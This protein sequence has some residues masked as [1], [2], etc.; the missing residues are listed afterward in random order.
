M[1]HAMRAVEEPAG[2]SIQRLM[3]KAR[4]RLSGALD[5]E[6]HADEML[7]QNK[8]LREMH[9]NDEDAVR[10]DALD[11]LSFITRCVLDDIRTGLLAHMDGSCREVFRLGELLDM[12]VRPPDIHQ[13]VYQR[14]PPS[15]PDVRAES[16]MPLWGDFHQPDHAGG[17]L[18]NQSCAPG[19]FGP[20]HGWEE[21]ISAIWSN[22]LGQELSAPWAGN[23]VGRRDGGP[24]REVLIRELQESAIALLAGSSTAGHA[25]D[26]AMSEVNDGDRLRHKPTARSKRNKFVIN[27]YVK[28]R[29]KSVREIR[30]EANRRW[31][32][33]KAMESDNAINRIIARHEEKTGQRIPRRKQSM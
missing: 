2:D 30:D 33:L 32:R 15:E 22:V 16:V 11:A 19:Q 13:R 26:G 1:G 5:S 21:S 24:A 4:E 9:P 25:Q 27:A 20:A 29:E 7:I 3:A 12:G 10:A 8:R 17:V 31:P 18:A 14:P 28:Q 6:D 23:D